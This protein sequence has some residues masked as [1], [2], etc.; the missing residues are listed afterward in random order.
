[1]QPVCT[2]AEEVPSH[3]IF[4]SLDLAYEQLQTIGFLSNWKWPDKRRCTALEGSA[5]TALGGRHC[6]ALV[7]TDR[8]GLEAAACKVRITVDSYSQN[9]G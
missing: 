8:A 6:G 3:A 1:V 7:I 4:L 9:G 5:R 2:C